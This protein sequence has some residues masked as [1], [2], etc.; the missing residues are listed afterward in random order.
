DVNYDVFSQGAG[1]ANADRATRIAQRLDGVSVTPTVWTPG[2]YQGRAYE[3]FVSLMAP[4]QSRPGTFTVRNA[5]ITTPATWTLS[6]SV[7]RRTATV[8][9]GFVTPVDGS[10]NPIDFWNAI[11]AASPASDLYGPGV[12]RV[13]PAGLTPLAAVSQ[14]DWINADLVRITI[15]SPQTAFDPG[16]DGTNDYRYMVDAY[17]WTETDWATP[18]P[19]TTGF[20]DLNRI[21]INH[22]EANVFSATVH[23]GPIRTQDGLV[24]RLRLFGTVLDGLPR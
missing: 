16:G 5:N 11:L 2:T 7:F 14:S 17:D 12:Y 21:T 6:D 19:D 1:F 20:T 9:Y 15:S 3:A 10:L 18:I 4:G 8:E 13:T 22:P 24:F 23:N